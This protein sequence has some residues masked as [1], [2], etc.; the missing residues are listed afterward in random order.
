MSGWCCPGGVA[1]TAPRVWLCPS[2][3]RGPLPARGGPTSS[4]AARPAALALGRLIGGRRAA[5]LVKSKGRPGMG[6]P[7][8]SCRASVRLGRRARIVGGRGWLGARCWRAACWP[9]ASGPLPRGAGGPGRLAGGHACMLVRAGTHMLQLRV[10][11][12]LGLDLGT[13]GTRRLG[14][15]STSVV[16]LAGSPSRAACV[17]KRPRPTSTARCHFGTRR[18]SRLKP[19]FTCRLGAR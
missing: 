7:R 10:W 6:S 18:T 9:G 2:C 5:T 12:L 19:H 17:S 3:G 16:W 13:L 4:Q 11:A 15:S 14:W 8:R 1:R